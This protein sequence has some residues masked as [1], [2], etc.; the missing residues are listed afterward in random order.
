MKFLDNKIF[1][2][3]VEDNKDP[4]KKGRCG[5]KGAYQIDHI[6]PIQYGFMNNIPPE[7]LAS[8]INLQFISWE[9]NHKKGVHHA[10]LDIR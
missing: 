6:I 9:D 2:G 3:I 4:N 10:K 1:F 5:V 8:P 7:K